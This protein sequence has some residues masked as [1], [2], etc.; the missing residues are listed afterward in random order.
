MKVCK[1]VNVVGMKVVEYG[2]YKGER[3]D[4]GRVKEWRGF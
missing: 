1:N 2:L 4:V 3:V